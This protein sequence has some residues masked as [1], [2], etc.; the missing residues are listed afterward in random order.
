[1]VSYYYTTKVYTNLEFSK[2]ASIKYCN[3]RLLA[4]AAKVKLF[5]GAF[6]CF[7]AGASSLGKMKMKK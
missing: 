1:M 5:Y 6:V 3:Q 7:V 2:S 4:T